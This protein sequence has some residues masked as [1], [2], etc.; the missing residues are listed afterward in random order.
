MAGRKPKPINLK[1]ITGNPGKRPLNEK[2]PK[3][4]VGIPKCPEHLS[5]SAK[6]E[7]E[8]ISPEL[9]AMG[10]LTV[11][12]RAALAAYCQSF[13]TWAEAERLIQEKG[14]VEDTFDSEGQPT[15]TK[16]APA[17]NIAVKMLQQMR[18]FLT[19]FGLTPAS[20]SRIRVG[21]PDGQERDVA[22]KYFTRSS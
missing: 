5:D 9:V 21:G 22:E 14:I 1:L 18:A 10:V 15:G 8:R 20:R 3:P 7:W 4:M 2:E 13:A 19:E 16:A 6:E 11:S 12:D 17:V